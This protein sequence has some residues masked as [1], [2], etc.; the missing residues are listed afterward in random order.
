M[1]VRTSSRKVQSV[2]FSGFVNA[3]AVAGIPD[4][5]QRW[6]RTKSHEKSEFCV[7]WS[8]KNL[9]FIVFFLAYL[10]LCDVQ[11]VASLLYLTA[12]ARSTLSTNIF[13][14]GRDASHKPAFTNCT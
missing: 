3:R 9:T 2:L 6:Q 12:C 14:G 7:G 11:G 10:A 1:R 4:A 13:A 5:Q 8:H